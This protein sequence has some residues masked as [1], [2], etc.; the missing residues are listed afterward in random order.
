[1]L[2]AVITLAAATPVESTLQIGVVPTAV[3]GVEGNAYVKSIL[4][5]TAVTWDGAYLNG[6][7]VPTQG[8]IRSF[9]YAYLGTPL[10][11]QPMLISATDIDGTLHCYDVLGDLLDPFPLLLGC[12]SFTVTDIDGDGFDDL[13]LL[14]GEVQPALILSG[15][16]TYTARDL[17]L[18]YPDWSF[19]VPD[20]DLDGYA[21][22][23]QVD[24]DFDD[25]TNPGD[26]R[27]CY[28]WPSTDGC[29]EAW[30]STTSI[31]TG[32]PEG[33][34]DVPTVELEHD[35]IIHYGTLRPI[36]HDADPELELIGI[37]AKKGG[38]Y[39]DY[40]GALV[41]LDLTDP[42]SLEVL[43]LGE[44]AWDEPEDILVID[45]EDFD[46]IDDVVIVLERGV[47]LHSSV[48]P[49]PPDEPLWEW[50]G[51]DGL[52]IIRDAIAHDL[53]QD[54]LKD[55]ILLHDHEVHVFFAP[56]TYEL[57]EDTGHTGDTA[58]TTETGDTNDTGTPP[59]SST[60]D[61]ASTTDTGTA[62][63]TGSTTASGPICGCQAT[64]GAPLGLLPIPLMLLFRRRP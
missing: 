64:A 47:Y 36:Q 58:Q 59:I 1:M 48:S 32:S 37:A 31:Y 49:G 23:V 9:S 43:A 52:T 41:L 57:P 35:R 63:D 21:D 40:D 46:G 8:E 17:G 20:L 5:I 54:G 24:F 38:D 19:P 50:T 44:R 10:Y 45:D 11:G 15:T 25:R 7:L 2:V 22:V 12:P 39:I 33:Y 6:S 14:T 53:D 26:D 16:G 51:P 18:P 28:G 3:V 30:D 55:L 61:T 60:G 13:H 62:A 56:F 34:L 4:G 27:D 29:L 42:A